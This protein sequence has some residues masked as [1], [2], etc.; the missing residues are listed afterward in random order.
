MFSE[1]YNRKITGKYRDIITYEDGRVE[2]K[3]WDYN[4]II[5][6]V[7][8]L[9]T[10]LFKS[11]SGYAGLTYWAVGS[12]VSTWDSTNPPVAVPTDTKCINE[13]GRIAIPTS[14]IEFL[15]SNGVVTTTVTNCIR[16]TVTFAPTDCIGTWREFSIFGGNATATLN[17]GI[18]INH[19]NHAV[20][21]KTNT[22][23]VQRQIIFTF[24]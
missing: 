11:Q 7:V 6:D 13:I 1:E 24:N 23:T 22:M 18:A 14:G 3:P 21:S 5:N 4:C 10:C 19:K 2:I 16:V 17:S 15:D 8:K 12:G 9:I 20:L